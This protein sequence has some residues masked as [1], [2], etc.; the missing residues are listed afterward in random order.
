MKKLRL[1]PEELHV[2]SFPSDAAPEGRGTVAGHSG[3]G[4]C[5]ACQSTMNDVEC[6]HYS[7]YID[8][9]DIVP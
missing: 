7:V 6:W 3:Y 4:T 1:N 2:E 5:G 8:C 9:P